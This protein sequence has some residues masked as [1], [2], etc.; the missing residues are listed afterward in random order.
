MLFLADIEKKFFI[1]ASSSTERLYFCVMAAVIK[2][3]SYEARVREVNE[4]YDAHSRSGLSNREI[5][6]RYIWPKYRIS[7][8]TFYNYI[9]ASADPHVIEKIDRMQLSLQFGGN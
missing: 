3:Y 6:R 2:G 9:N 7:E 1:Y 5:L 4:I 8:K